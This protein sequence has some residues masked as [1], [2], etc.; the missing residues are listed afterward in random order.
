MV[1]IA[2]LADTAEQ[3]VVHLGMVGA[4]QQ[5]ESGTFTNGNPVAL[6][7]KPQLIMRWAMPKTLALEEQAVETT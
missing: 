3:D 2:G 7:I 5:D 4:F 6:R 1:G